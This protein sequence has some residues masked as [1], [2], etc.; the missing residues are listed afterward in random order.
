MPKKD[1]QNSN[2]GEAHKF[3]H[4]SAYFRQLLTWKYLE[5]DF[6]V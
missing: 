5:E 3:L 4:N 1:E 2:S 6:G